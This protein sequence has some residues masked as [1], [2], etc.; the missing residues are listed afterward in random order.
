MNTPRL[1]QRLLIALIAAASASL[2]AEAATVIKADNTT[3]ISS[4]GSWV[5]G[6]LPGTGDIGLF[7]STITTAITTANLGNY[8]IASLELTNPGGAVTIGIGSAST[9]TLNTGGI[10]MSAATVDLTIGTTANSGFLR[11]ASANFSTPFNVATGRTLTINSQLTNQGNNKNVVFTGPGNIILNGT[12]GGGTAF[13]FSIQGGSNV[14]MNAANSWGGSGVKEIINGTLNIGND[15]ALNG[16]TLTLG[17]TSSATPTIAATGGARTIS[18]A[19]TL[20]AVTTGNATIAGTNDLTV[21]GVLTVSGGD[22]TLTV[23][24]TGLTTF[25]TGGVA[26]ANSGTNRTLT[27]NG[28]GNTT[29]SGIIVNGSTSTAGNLTY[30]GTGLLSLT[31][32]NTFGGILTQSSGTVRIDN[33]LAAQSAT[34]S[35]GTND[36]VT[37]GTGIT[38]ATFG[39][40]SG[41]GNL[42]MT[43]TDLAAV[44]LQVGNSNANSTYTGTLGGTGTLSKIGTGTLTLSGATVG[45]AVVN[46]NTGTLA[47]GSSAGSGVGTVN[48][49]NGTTVSA[50]SGVGGGAVASA[51]SITGT[52]A[53]VTLTNANG[54]G[55][56]GSN[57]SGSADQTLTV[58]NAGGQA[59]NLN[60]TSPQLTNFLGTVIVSSGATLGFRA[61]SL[62][63]GGT[64]TTF[65]VDGNL[66]TRNN[67][68]L[69]IG[70]LTGTGTLGMGTSG[71]DNATLTYT[72]GGK[73][74]DS[75]FSGVI[76]DGD[77]A[78]G[79]RVLIT[80]TGTGT[81]TLSG[82]NTYTGLTT[83]NAGV[84]ALGANNTLDADNNVRLNGGSLFAGT[85]A[86][87]LGTLDLD[88]SSSISFGTGGTLSFA[89]S[90]SQNW[91]AFA[92]SVGGTFVS[93]E[94]IR[95]GSDET[96]L[97]SGQLS[98]ITIAGFESIAINSSGFITA[99]AGSPVPEPATYALLAGLGIL[100]FAAYRRRRA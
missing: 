93:G 78:T 71:S 88:A 50:T 97:S 57:F 67:G 49:A 3:A 70:A 5:G 1:S 89:N 11:I 2:S 91:G 72:I 43:N 44:A 85:F 60:A 8:T 10:N 51:I 79:K 86:N 4:A 77:I 32:A 80:K 13:G 30:S 63:N 95:F 61:T 55:G 46:L 31:N 81:L 59:V 19:I 64:N 7:D 28:S 69:A 20:A 73:N 14:T 56:F 98:L 12:S 29:I 99:T 58:S 84:L 52:N 53:N 100:G 9:L 37:F 27:I 87:T 35:V 18:S 17:G 34:V 48:A 68:F 6:V 75:T 22:R 54:S 25:G 23:N 90:A 92:L 66:T 83:V 74:I 94:S 45:A 39:G 26:L 47:F 96:G 33:S 65:Q 62:N 38:A 82:V 24:N 15:S 16:A 76:Q 40:L 41:A 21:N 42:T 36:G